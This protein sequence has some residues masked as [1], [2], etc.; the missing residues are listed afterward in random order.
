MDVVTDISGPIYSALLLMLLIYAAGLL[1]L[2][3][4]IKMAVKAGTAE[5]RKQT[6][7]TNRLL[8]EQLKAQGCSPEKLDAILAGGA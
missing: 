3:F 2:F 5:Q 6:I 1:V 4:I 7:I 8:A